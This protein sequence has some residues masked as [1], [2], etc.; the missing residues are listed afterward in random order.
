MTGERLIEVREPGRVPLRVLVGDRLPV[1]RGGDG[2]LLG[3]DRVS[4]HHCELWVEGGALY[5]RDAGSSNGTLVNGARLASAERRALAPGDVV[6]IGDAELRVDPPSP[7]PA[8]ADPSA[9]DPLASTVVGAPTTT[10]TTTAAGPPTAASN[11]DAGLD[12]DLR[13]S[14]VGGTITMV[15]SDIVDSTALNG[16]L[17]DAEWLRLLRRHNELI[18]GLVARFQGAEIKTQ[19]D[20]FM[21]TFPSARH[22]L[23]LGIAVQRALAE[24]RR[25]DPSFVLHVRIGVHTGEVIHDRGD[26][27]G[28]HVSLAA[29][30]GAIAQADE[31]L[32]SSLV[33]ELASA[34]GDVTF[35]EPR[36]AHF[37][38]FEGERS[39]FP[40][41]WR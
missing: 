33:H 2:L 35:G 20:G 17:G 19:G 38:G 28:R 24:E 13:A 5:V 32:A 6:A 36:P 29:R 25:T 16:A 41:A 31:V 14:V 15:F 40:V 1:G 22:A 23:G 27:F 3:G 11:V 39:V 4:R 7:T 12:A 9:T 10:A 34:M 26:I 21:L 30:V 8:A 37:K 18:R